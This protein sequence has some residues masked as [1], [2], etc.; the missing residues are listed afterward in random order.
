VKT[1][2]DKRGYF[3]EKWY[4]PEENIVYLPE[5]PERMKR[6]LLS[7]LFFG[8]VVWGWNTMGEAMVS[9]KVAEETQQSVTCKAKQHV[10][11]MLSVLTEANRWADVSVRP[12]NSLPTN[13]I[14]RY[15][16]GVF[17]FGCLFV[18][19]RAELDTL[20]NYVFKSFLELSQEYAAHLK[21]AGYYIY[22]LR[23]MIV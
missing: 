12:V 23:K 16:P 9:L 4:L 1:L 22:T 19:L 10:D 8:G 13:L 18:C 2:S 5:K 14:R 3:F 6:I 17:S 21:D 20:A 15:R 11:Y 7:I